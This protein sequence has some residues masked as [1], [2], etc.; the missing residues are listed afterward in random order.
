M[1]AA[2]ILNGIV[3]RVVVAPSL[4]WCVDNLGG[5]WVETTD[6]YG[7]DTELAYTGPGHGYDPSFPE[8]FAPQ[9]EPWDG[10][11][12]EDNHTPYQTG[13]LVFHEG[14][15]WV[16]TTNDNV[17]EPGVSGWQDSPLTGL[18]QWI[19]P[20][21]AHDA[22]ALGAQVT[23]NGQNWESTTPANVWEPG[24]FGWVVI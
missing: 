2:E 12:D 5:E 10:L 4:Q 11:F 21:G 22:Y 20:T 9:W 3:Q 8:A 14:S 1:Y 15:I 23:H 16:S 19:Q 18:P 13:S 7:P 24:V 17:W 6:P